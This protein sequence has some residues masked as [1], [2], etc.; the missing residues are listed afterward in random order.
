MKKEMLEIKCKKCKHEWSPRIEE[1]PKSCPKCKSYKWNKNKEE[2]K[3]KKKETKQKDEIDK[4][5]KE[6][7]DEN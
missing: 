7:E 3:P 2:E 4:Y 1:P 6:N 5:Y